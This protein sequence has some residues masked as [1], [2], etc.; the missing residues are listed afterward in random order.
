[1]HN[2]FIYSAYGLVI[3]SELPLPEAIPL[4]E[5][6]ADASIRRGKIDWSPRGES[7]FHFTAEEAYFF[8]E[9]LGKFLVRGG[10]EIVVESISGAEDRLVRLPLLGVVLSVLLHQRGLMVLHA[11]AVAIEG[12]AVAFLGNKGEGKSTTAAMLYARGHSLVAD[13]AVVLDFANP[14]CPKVIPGFPQFKL[15]PEAAAMI[16]EDPEALPR[17]IPGL[18][19]RARQIA[20]R[21]STSSLPLKGIYLLGSGSLAQLEPLQP[22]QALLHLIAHTYVSRFGNKLLSAEKANVHLGQCAKLVRA[23]PI[24]LLR[25]PGHLS[26]L[27]LAAELIEANVKGRESMTDVLA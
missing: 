5:A 27:P 20:D 18:E 11:S 7:C 9:G 24:Y 21:F 17:L 25:R 22:Q 26:A 4:A 12:Q 10:N 1:M 13:D 6:D 14:Q 3:H 16:G 23:V 15:W 2:V 19:K 8:W